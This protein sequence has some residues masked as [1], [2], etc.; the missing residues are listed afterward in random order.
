MECPL[1][2]DRLAKVFGWCAVLS[3]GLVLLLFVI[4]LVAGDFAFAL[5]SKMFIL[6]RM[7]FEMMYYC[8]LALTKIVALLLFVVPY[9]AIKLVIKNEGATTAGS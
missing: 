7:Q 5:H 1:S 3:L 9:I 2:L 6:E 8:G 4:Y